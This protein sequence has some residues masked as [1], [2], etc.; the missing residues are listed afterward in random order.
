MK[1]CQS[2]WMLFV[3]DDA[4]VGVFVCDLPSSPHPESLSG[5]G[6]RRWS[7]ADHYCAHVLCLLSGLSTGLAQSA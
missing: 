7:R 3:C 5:L 4:M 2:A 6:L 1:A